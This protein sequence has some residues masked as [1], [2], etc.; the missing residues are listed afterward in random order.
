[1]S[2]VTSGN[3]R[4]ER[5]AYL[6]ST[7]STNVNT[8]LAAT[9]NVKDV[10]PHFLG[11]MNASC[12][13]CDA[14]FWIQERKPGT[15]QQNPVF[16]LCCRDG[17]F[18]LPTF[19]SPPSLLLELLQGTTNESKHNRN[20]IRAY[21]SAFSF[22]SSGANFDRTL[23][24]NC[25]GVYTYR[26]QG[27]VYHQI[28]N[29]L[30][31]PIGHAPSF[32]QIYIYDTDYQIERR[33]SIFPDL[34]RSI[35]EKI[36]HCLHVANPFVT[37]FQ[38]NDK[39]ALLTASTQ[40]FEL[41]IGEP[42]IPDRCYDQPNASEI[43]VLMTGDGHEGDGRRSI[44]LRKRGGG[45]QFVNQ[46]NGY[47]DLLHF[48]LL[49]PYGSPGWSLQLKESAHVTMNQFYAYHFMVRD[50]ST[51]LHLSGRLF[52]EYLVDV[53]AKVEESRLHWIRCNQS[54]LRLS[55]Y[56][57]LV[58]QVATDNVAMPAGR[59]IILPPSFTGGP[60]YMQGLYQDAMAIVNTI[61]SKQE[62]LQLPLLQT[63]AL[64]IILRIIHKM[65]PNNIYTHD[66]YLHQRHSG[67][68]ANSVCKK[69]IQLFLPYKFT[70]R[71]CKQWCTQK[72]K[73][74]LKS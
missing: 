61:A 2:T 38:A 31:P 65:K 50:S 29:A 44:V 39:Q 9:R 5:I 42:S 1:M 47:Y 56:R 59:M 7:R 55:L 74:L 13:S 37:Q 34:H 30:L 58:D 15:S 69:C 33:C 73:Q 48:V 18:T 12:A 67:E 49:F 21:N 70:T 25:A 26:I 10:Q 17:K 22:T 53:Y 52:Q 40:E 4:A 28:S 45:L 35:L 46:L 11:V 60:R 71:I 19:P 16:H 63:S 8:L 20:F 68:S 64:A 36:Q 3:R 62:F 27:A 32:A 66:T 14:K 72:E 54:T 43:A 51:V 57:G 23:A 41:R 24:D 6:R